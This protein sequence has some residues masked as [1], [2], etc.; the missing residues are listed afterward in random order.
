M[1][2]QVNGERSVSSMKIAGG[3]KKKEKKIAEN[4]GNPFGKIMNQGTI[5][6]LEE[7]RRLSL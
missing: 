3:K 6:L 1:P 2:S 5:K 7:N 4:I